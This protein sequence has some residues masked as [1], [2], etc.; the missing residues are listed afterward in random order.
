V[1]NFSDDAM[2][3][4]TSAIIFLG[5]LLFFALFAPLFQAGQA[6]ALKREHA[7]DETPYDFDPTLGFY[8]FDT[9]DYSGYPGFDDTPTP[10]TTLRPGETRAATATRQPGLTGTAKLTNAATNTT[11]GANLSPS[12]SPSPRFS[13]TTGRNLYGTE[14]AEMASAR[15]SPPPSETPQATA[16]RT[17]VP[18]PTALQA[19]QESFQLDKNWFLGGIVVSLLLVLAFWFINK[20]RESGEFK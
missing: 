6:A 5:F 4:L 1:F 7:Q 17:P 12:P 20:L 10:T 11:P 13:P 2:R 8:I 19:E 9:P 14:D 3:R 18:S 15:I 16:S